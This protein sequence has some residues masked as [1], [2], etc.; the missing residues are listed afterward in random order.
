MLVVEGVRKC[1]YDGN[2]LRHA[3]KLQT[4][5]RYRITM[6]HQPEYPDLTNCPDPRNIRL[7]LY[8][9]IEGSINTPSTTSVG[10]TRYQSELPVVI[11]VSNFMYTYVRLTEGCPSR[12]VSLGSPLEDVILHFDADRNGSALLVVPPTIGSVSPWLT[13]YR[14]DG[15]FISYG[16][17]HNFPF[18]LPG[19]IVLGEDSVFVPKRTPQTGYIDIGPPVVLVWRYPEYVKKRGMVEA[20]EIVPDPELPLEGPERSAEVLRRM[21]LI[22]G[23]RST[24]VSKEMALLFPPE[25]D[26]KTSYHEPSTSGRM[27]RRR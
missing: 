16:L 11:R 12:F 4:F 1:R 6:P 26:R 2:V 5:D 25:K 3:E 7:N 23:I 9:G 15:F 24:P 10:K 13:F 19:D 18:G 17:R 22:S 14:N 20:F 8:Q 27:K 21:R